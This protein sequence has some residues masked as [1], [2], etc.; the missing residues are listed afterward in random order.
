MTC[1]EDH[2][3]IDPRTLHETRK[4]PPPDHPSSFARPACLLAR[5]RAATLQPYP[6]AARRRSRVVGSTKV[7]HRRLPKASLRK[8]IVPDPTKK[9]PKY[10]R[11]SASIDRALALFESNNLQE[12]ADYI[13]FLGRLLKVRSRGCSGSRDSDSTG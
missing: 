3:S 8:L 4:I 12:W 1:P 11:F 2:Q 10:K 7:V 5:D 13:S 6:L 9:D